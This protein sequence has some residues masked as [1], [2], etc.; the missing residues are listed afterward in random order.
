MGG[1]QAG[2]LGSGS[3]LRSKVQGGTLAL[4]PLKGMLVV[5]LLSRGET[6]R[7]PPM[8]GGREVVQFSVSRARGSGLESCV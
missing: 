1:K 8:A 7:V 3:H 2:A 6:L 5:S 4:P